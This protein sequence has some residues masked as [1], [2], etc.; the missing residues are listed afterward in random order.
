MQEVFLLL[1]QE[2]IVEAFGRWL[3]Q[4]LCKGCGITCDGLLMYRRDVRGSLVVSSVSV[5]PWEK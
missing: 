5:V 3:A 2:V 1:L 4:C